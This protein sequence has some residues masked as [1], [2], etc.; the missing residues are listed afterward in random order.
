MMT[1]HHVTVRVIW[2][3]DLNDSPPYSRYIGYRRDDRQKKQDTDVQDPI[4]AVSQISGVCHDTG[5]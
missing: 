1:V 2:L 3:L 4:W 5:A